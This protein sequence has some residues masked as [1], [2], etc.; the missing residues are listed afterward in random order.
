MP[1]GQIGTGAE[2]RSFGR[3][4]ADPDTGGGEGHDRSAKR[5]GDR[6]TDGVATFGANYEPSPENMRERFQIV[7]SDAVA[8]IPAGR[9][10]QTGRGSG[11][12][13]Q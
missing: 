12:D 3:E 6:G 8:M 13:R 9:P 10:A 2:H 1:L 11:G 5:P 4:N 7:L